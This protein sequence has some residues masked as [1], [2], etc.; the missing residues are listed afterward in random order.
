M[1]VSWLCCMLLSF[2][3]LMIRRP[4]RS[5]RTD[6]LFPY[7]TLFRSAVEPD[8]FGERQDLLLAEAAAARHQGEMEVLI[9]A[10]ALAQGGHGGADGLH[11]FRAEDGTFLH[12]HAQHRIILDGRIGRA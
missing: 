8:G 11:R 10:R 5:T 3:F 2:F 4:P 1:I 7:T 12:H 6:T 9:L